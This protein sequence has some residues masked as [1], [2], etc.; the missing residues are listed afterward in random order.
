MEHA[1]RWGVCLI[2]VAGLLGGAAP[3]A[4]SEDR[5][6]VLA[7]PAAVFCVEQGGRYDIRTSNDGGQQG[8]CVFADGTEM[9]AWTFFREQS[10][11]LTK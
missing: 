3:E 5:A 9:D 1:V 4:V 2:S 10:D 8:F 6:A 7:N 11:S